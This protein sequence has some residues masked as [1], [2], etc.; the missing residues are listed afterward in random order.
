MLVRTC[1][2]NPFMFEPTATDIYLMLDDNFTHDSASSGSVETLNF[3]ANWV[4]GMPTTTGP[5]FL[6]SY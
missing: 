5:L 6:L 1:V 2:D 4:K 3:P